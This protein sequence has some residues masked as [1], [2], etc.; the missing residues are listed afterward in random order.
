MNGWTTVAPAPEEA[1]AVW[2]AVD[3]FAASPTYRNWHALR[4]AV[5]ALGDDDRARFAHALRGAMARS[6]LGHSTTR[7]APGVPH[8]L[9]NL[10]QVPGHQHDASCSIHAV[11]GGPPHDPWAYLLEALWQV[12]RR[13]RM[14]D[15]LTALTTR[16]ENRHLRPSPYTAWQWLGVAQEM[17]GQ[18][19]AAVPNG[20][21]VVAGV[22]RALLRLA[23]DGADTN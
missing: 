7:S 17:D 1:P 6:K 19:I 14:P 15:A 21:E 3:R 2:D 8:Y 23:R 10:P 20:P 4:D 9:R 18:A 12:C 22:R 13:A 16:L 11:L 5:F